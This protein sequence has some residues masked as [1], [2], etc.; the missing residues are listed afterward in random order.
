MTACRWPLVAFLVALAELPV[1]AGDSHLDLPIP[2][3]ESVLESHPLTILEASRSRPRIAA[4]ITLRAK[5]KFGADQRVVEVKLR[6]AERGGGS[7][8]NEPRYELAA[9]HLQFMFLDPADYVVPPT[10]VHALAPSDLAAHSEAGPTFRAADD[11]ICVA[12]AWLANVTNPADVFDK[13]RFES[14]VEYA[15]QVGNLN[16]FTVAINHMDSNRG[17]ILTSRDGP[18]R[19]F[20]V[21]N[22]VAFAS[23][24]SDRGEVWRKLRVD[25]LPAAVVERLR[26]IDES[27]LTERLAVLAQ[28]RVVE[29]RLVSQSPGENVNPSRGVRL[30]G[31]LIQLGLSTRE[32]KEIA[33]RMRRILNLVDAGKVKTF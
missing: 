6:P 8:N 9:Y 1:H 10:A 7:F 21:D 11:I 13:A 33:Q 23:K 29:R 20:A 26:H 4:D 15:R 24:R 3:F 14:D 16:V 27:K 25:R 22:G 12:Q 31:D 2:A 28:W 32:I 18:P 30:K 17:N 5:A 19:F